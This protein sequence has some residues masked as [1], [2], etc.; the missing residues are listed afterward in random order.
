MSGLK[1][2]RALLSGTG[3]S[4]RE[5]LRELIMDTVTEDEDVL[6][7]TVGCSMRCTSCSP[8][9]SNGGTVK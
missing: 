7:C 6:R 9:C 3:L 4:K 5:L 1:E 8:G 2:I